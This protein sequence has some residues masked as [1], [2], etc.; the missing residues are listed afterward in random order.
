M[1]SMSGTSDNDICSKISWSTLSKNGDLAITLGQ[2]AYYASQLD[3]QNMRKSE[4]EG[5]TN[6]LPIT[7]RKLV[8]NTLQGNSYQ[9]PL[10]I[11]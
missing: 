8:K 11:A 10:T 3:I 9:T 7:A 6:F 1:V 2:V 4:L 5:V